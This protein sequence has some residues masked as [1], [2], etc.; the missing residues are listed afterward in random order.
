VYS[1][2]TTPRGHPSKI[3]SLNWVRANFS[4]KAMCH[5]R[6][7]ERSFKV[8]CITRIEDVTWE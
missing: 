4:V 5:L 2:G 8:G 7:A 3:T 1:G 6:K